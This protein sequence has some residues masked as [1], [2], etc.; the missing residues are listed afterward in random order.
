MMMGL[1]LFRQGYVSLA[2]KYLNV[3]LIEFK[4]VKSKVAANIFTFGNK[5]LYNQQLRNNRKYLPK[6]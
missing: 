4:N 1:D 2:V 3:I 5:L 6:V